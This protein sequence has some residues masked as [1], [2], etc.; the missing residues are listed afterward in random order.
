MKGARPYGK[1]IKGQYK[2]SPRE[3]S[4]EQEMTIRKV[5]HMNG[6]HGRKYL[7]YKR[8]LPEVNKLSLILYRG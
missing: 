8:P 6:K 4:S 1:P 3:T 2:D 5:D 7:I